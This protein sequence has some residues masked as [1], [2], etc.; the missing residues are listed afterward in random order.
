MLCR[1][2]CPDARDAYALAMLVA[3]G[4]EVKLIA[5]RRSPDGDPLLPSRLLLLADPETTAR[6]VGRLF[7]EGASAASGAI[8]PGRLAPG[9]D[10]SG[11]TVPRPG[12]SAEHSARRRAAAWRA[13]RAAH[14]AD[15]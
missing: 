12:A 8:L 1:Q 2:V 7:R 9:R 3:S 14:P 15:R 11:F 10:E 13:G 4:R 5:G 6:R